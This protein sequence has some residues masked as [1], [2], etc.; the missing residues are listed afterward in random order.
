MLEMKL[1]SIQARDVLV[2]IKQRASDASGEPHKTR[3][4]WGKTTH[5][6]GNMSGMVSAKF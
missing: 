6:H 3:V 2:C 4:I 5:A 1:N